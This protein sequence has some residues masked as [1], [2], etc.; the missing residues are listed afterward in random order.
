MRQSNFYIILFSALLTV[1]LGGLLS[2]AAVG[3]KPMQDLQV[4]LDTQNKILSAVMDVGPD[5]DVPTIYDKRIR[6]EVVN[7]KGE[8]V[9][10]VDGEPVVAEKVSI[11]SQFDKDPEDRI[12]PIYKFVNENNPEQVDAYIL[13]VY[14][15][16]LW[17]DIWG[18]VALQND[19]KTLKGVVFDHAGETP[20][21]GA[22]I[23]SIDVQERFQE[24]KIYDQ[25]GKLVAV[26]MVKGE[27]GD[28]SMYGDNEVDGLSGA[29]ITAVGVNDM[30]YNYLTYYEAYLEKVA[31]KSLEKPDAE[32]QYTDV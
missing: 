15:T 11:A 17:D 14:G 5:D 30:L 18:Y 28:P 29:T 8:V 27:S 7:I 26:R 12:Y 31:G 4:A 19:L 10:E 24:K 22:R 3:L 23:T 21:L 2:L 9:E 1:V 16:G 32:K 20:G 6:A 13:P 25:T